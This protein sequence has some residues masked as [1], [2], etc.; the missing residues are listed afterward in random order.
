[1]INII[2][3]GILGQCSVGACPRPVSVQPALVPAVT[4][5]VPLAT[6]P[7]PCSVQ[8]QAATQN[9]R[10]RVRVRVRRGLGRNCR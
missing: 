1:M 7:A 4:V 5:T 2:L 6:A 8:A 9:S 10:V 3:A